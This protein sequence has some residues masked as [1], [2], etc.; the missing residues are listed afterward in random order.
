MDIR[1]IFRLTQGYRKRR[2]ITWI[3]NLK[4]KGTTTLRILII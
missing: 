3:K 4:I 1:D 2:S